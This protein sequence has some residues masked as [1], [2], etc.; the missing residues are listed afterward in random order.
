MLSSAL[1]VLTPALAHASYYALVGSRVVI[2]AADVSQFLSSRIDNSLRLK[3]WVVKSSE[4]PRAR[5]QQPRAAVV[6]RRWR[7]GRRRF[8]LLNGL[9]GLLQ[10]E[11]KTRQRRKGAVYMI[12]V[13]F[14]VRWRIRIPLRFAYLWFNFSR[15]MADHFLHF[16]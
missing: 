5:D 8:H 4:F 3:M 15:R 9:P 1:T 11:I 13:F 7:E 14:S 12:F 6:S 2:G 10:I 16:W